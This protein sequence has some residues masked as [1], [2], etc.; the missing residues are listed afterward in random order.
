MSKNLGNY[1][2]PNELMDKYSAD[3]LR[4]VLLASPVLNGEDFSL[5]DKDVSDVA[6]KLSMVWNMYDFFTMY[7]DVDGWEFTG[8]LSDPHDDCTNPLDQWVISRVHQLNLEV[9]KH[10]DAYDIPN[11]MK[12]I[13][14]FIEDASNWYV[15]RSRRRFWKSGDDAD[16]NNAYRTLHY[17]LVQLSQIMAPFTPF[18][19]EELYQNLTD[20]ESVHLLDWPAAGH[21]NELVVQDMETVREYVNQGLSMRAK[22]R[23]KVRQPLA[24]VTVPTLGKFVSFE[25]I[26]TEELNV[27]K[28]IQGEVLA[29]DFDLTDDLKA[30]GLMREVV[31]YVQSARKAAGLNVDDHISLNLVTDSTEL[32][33]AIDKHL[34]TIKAETLADKIGESRENEQMVKVEGNE[35]TIALEKV[36]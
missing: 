21:V 8:D 14:P 12:Q 23:M 25:D 4:Y 20:G 6:R 33:Q 32:Q 1:T 16:K 5:K 9:E 27:K 15:R 28:V 30:E 31:R 10:M 24:S 26:L 17:V 3:S 2:D 7:A 11:A 19:A 34:D 18:L 13:L 36:T 35:L 29:L 22:E